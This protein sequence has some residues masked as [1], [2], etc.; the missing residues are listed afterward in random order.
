MEDENGKYIMSFLTEANHCAPV[1]SFFYQTNSDIGAISTE[2][3][4]GLEIS[5]DR[6]AELIADR[7]GIEKLFDL[8]V[9]ENVMYLKSRLKTFQSLDA[10]ERFHLLMKQHPEVLNRFSMM[11]IS[12]YLGIKP[13]TL[14]RLRRHERI[15][16]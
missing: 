7:P 14:S 2:D 1:K 15:R 11:D 12:N 9:H 6:F 8:L 10:N 16:K 3:I 4:Y 5:Y 13:E